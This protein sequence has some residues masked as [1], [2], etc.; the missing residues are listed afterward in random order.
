MLP[1]LIQS[2]PVSLGLASLL[3]RS[4]AGLVHGLLVHSVDI[5]DL[6]FVYSSVSTIPRLFAAFV[7]AAVLSSSIRSFLDGFLEPQL[8]L[9]ATWLSD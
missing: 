8:C 5:V 6:C 9:A 1:S 2:V 3:F 7:V 4:L